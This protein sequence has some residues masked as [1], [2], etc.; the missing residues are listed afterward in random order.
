MLLR[1]LRL[2][3]PNEDKVILYFTGEVVTRPQRWASEL[4]W[5]ELAGPG[6]PRIVEGFDKPTSQPFVGCPTG[7]AEVAHRLMQLLLEP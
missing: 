5:D 6:I 3:S 7:G 1:D 4:T 2:P